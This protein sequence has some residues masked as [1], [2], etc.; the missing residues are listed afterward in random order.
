ME[1]R[2]EDPLHHVADAIVDG[3][4]VPWDTLDTGADSETEPVIRE[5][6]ILAALADVHRRTHEP[7]D[8]LSPAAGM[9]RLP[10]AADLPASWGP[11]ELRAVLGSGSFGTVYRARDPRLDRDVALKLVPAADPAGLG[12]VVDE[13]RRLARVR[14]PNVITVFG[15]DVFDG[16]AGIWMELLE[17]HT[18]HEELRDRGPLGAREAALVGIDL[19]QALA[20]VH[21]VG[22]VHRDI[23][24]QNVM[25]QQGGRI[26]LMDFG[27]GREL[28]RAEGQAGTP[29]YM[30]PEL[31]SGASASVPSDIYSIG[32]LLFHLVTREFPVSARTLDDLS[33]RHAAG[34]RRRLRD[35]RPDLP[36]T[37]IRAV[38]HATASNPA[39]R[40]ASAAAL[41]EALESVV[42]GRERGGRTAASRLQGAALVAAL[43]LLISL[44]VWRAD[45]VFGPAPTMRSIAVV[46]FE[47]PDGR[48]DQ[49]PVADGLTQLITSNLE[50]MRSLRVIART[51]AKAVR[52]R[53]G[54]PTEIASQLNVDGLVTGSV[55]KR[56]DRVLV[57][58]RLLRADGS[59]LWTHDY[60]RP[61][62]DV[63]NIPGE[64]ALM[65]ADAIRVSLT[66]AERQELRESVVSVA[67]QE[68]Y[69]RGLHRMN[70]PRAETLRLAHADLLEAARLDP[71]SARIQAALSRCYVLLASRNVMTHSEAYPR[72]LTAATTAVQLDDRVA[73]AHTQL[74]EAKLYYEYQWD[75]AER[76]YE[77]ALELS[78]SNS[79]AMTRYAL[80]LS[81]GGR[82]DD[83]LDWATLALSSDP[84]SPGP[85]SAPG[86]VLYYER[87]YEEAVSAF[88]QLLALPPNTLLATD[89]VGLARSYAALGRHDDAIAQ[90]QTAIKHQSAVD[91]WVA[92]LARIQAEAGRHEEARRLLRSLYEAGA[93]DTCPANLG[94][95][96]VALGEIDR[97]FEALNRGVDLR[98]QQMLWMQVDTR[99]DPIRADPRFQELMAR[100]GLPR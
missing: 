96:H 37:F 61:A 51:S 30:A 14:H 33:A 54:S 58:V 47:H 43:L 92:E 70:D 7:G 4:P 26:V 35:V 95:V 52:E 82:F 53:T 24:P 99:F 76:E 13:G 29:L 55:E 77:R 6:H 85:R 68:A 36:S 72:A 97:A 88:Q 67:A 89:R 69:L 21:Q 50:Q 19:C 18:L 64:V 74:A 60:E 93:M 84:L 22:L 44:V 10:Q 65:V 63:G 80:F 91:V 5:L 94:L 46:P 38:E 3:A 20:A 71:A 12:R 11:F 9:F 90:L 1:P 75:M 40:P 17:G 8:D 81:A 34:E 42:V 78:P 28:A 48:E 66:K 83:A 16:I 87:R 98:S 56:G 57:N 32:V 45:S 73:D 23:K 100:V 15:A 59:A 27:A 41:E 79:H 49:A 62:N 86:M 2:E 25:R 39:E 31:L